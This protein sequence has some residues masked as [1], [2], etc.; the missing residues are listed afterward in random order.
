MAIKLMP[1]IKQKYFNDNGAPL[2]GGK[3]YSYVAGTNSPADTY[4]DANG[5]LNTNPII[6][7]TAGGYRG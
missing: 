7:D 5:T 2:Q 1:Q 3:L 6:L 4:K